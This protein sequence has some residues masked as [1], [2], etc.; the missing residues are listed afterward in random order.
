M[1]CNWNWNHIIAF[2]CL[3]LLV[4]EALVFK[5]WHIVDD[6]PSNHMGDQGQTT[7]VTTNVTTQVANQSSPTGY[8][9]PGPFPYY[10]IRESDKCPEGEPP[11]FLVLLILTVAGEVETR[12]AI[13]QTWA[14]EN[15]APGVRIIRLFLLG[16]KEGELGRQQQKIVEAES[17]MHHDIIQQDFLDTYLNLTLKTLL[18]MNWVAM[19]CPRAS[20]VMKTDSDMFVNTL[21]LIQKLLRPELKPKTNYITGLIYKDTKPIRD[22]SSKWYISP[23]EYPNETY[24]DYCCGTGYVFSG[25]MATK[26]YEA[27][28]NI[29]FLRFEDV[30]VGMCLER[31][32]IK[33]TPSPDW[34]FNNWRVYYS[35]Y[36]YRNL[37]TVHHV[38]PRDMLEYWHN[39]W[40]D[41]VFWKSD[42]LQWEWVF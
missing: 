39:I 17:L 26:L 10:I 42:A 40:R 2:V 13:R 38:V 15:V 31:L 14:N 37:V 35:S 1:K 29:P 11:P 34:L 19:H 7:Q 36:R 23:E 5:V 21:F 3:S 9:T 25:D 6:H 24:P 20:Y 12:N 30:Y 8:P 18:G 4:L 33:P 28:V 16:V 41:G 32:G 27:S 22:K